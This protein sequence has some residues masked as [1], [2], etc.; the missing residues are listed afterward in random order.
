M[1]REQ[2]VQKFS[3]AGVSVEFSF[4]AALPD[5]PAKPKEETKTNEIANKL[6]ARLGH[7]DQA[8]LDG[9]G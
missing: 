7:I 9:V 2:R 8:L 4:A 1:L 6:R 5:R 3:G